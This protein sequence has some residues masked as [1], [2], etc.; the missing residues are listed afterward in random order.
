MYVLAVLNKSDER[1]L[2]KLKKNIFDIKK[3]K[4]FK[5]VSWHVKYYILLPWLLIQYFKYNLWHITYTISL[6]NIMYGI[7]NYY[8]LQP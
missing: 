8:E 2:N 4:K 1:F 6:C 3:N 5:F 7:L